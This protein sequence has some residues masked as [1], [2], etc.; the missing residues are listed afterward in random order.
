VAQKV[1][2][3][4]ANLGGDHADPWGLRSGGTSRDAAAAVSRVLRSNGGIAATVLAAL[5]CYW[6][7]SDAIPVSGGLGY[8]G[9]RYAR[10]VRSNPVLLFPEGPRAP[11]VKSK[12]DSYAARRFLPSTA[13]HFVM[14]AFD[15]PRT[16]D[17]VIA[18][19]AAVNLALLAL[20]IFCLCRAADAVGLTTR[21]KWMAVLAFQV[22]YANWKMP[23]FYPVL[24]D[25]FALALGALSLLF[26]LER[27][28]LG[29]VLIMVGGGFVWPTLPYFCFLL[30]AFPSASPG[31]VRPDTGREPRGWRT[32]PTGAAGTAAVLYLA[33]ITILVRN[34]YR[35]PGTPVKPLTN[36]VALSASVTALYVFFGLR[37]L[38]DS[39]G[40]WQ[41][42]RPLSVLRR[43]RAWVAGLLLV[44]I[45][46]GVASLAVSQADY[47]GLRFVTDTLFSSVTQPGIFCLAHIL[48]FGP[49]LILV[50]FLWGPMCRSIQRRGAGLTLCF[51][52][53]LAIGAGSESRKLMNF[54]PFVAL[55]LAER[56]DRS[57]R[58]A[59]H[60]G[61]LAILSL[62]VSKVWLPMGQDLPVPLLGTIP[63]RSLY[64]SSRGPWIDHASYV[65]QGAFVSIVAVLVYRSFGP[66]LRRRAPDAQDL[67][68]AA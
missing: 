11:F 38:L 9:I 35:I 57:V 45:E 58:G 22:S 4:A 64:V 39:P 29:L 13:L 30:L 59:W 34:D 47:S 5:C 7:L 53:A 26:Y 3:R 6:P 66:V 50:P 33:L 60:V 43:R 48:F 20:A 31:P 32:L 37:T 56:L 12:L 24:T 36:L 42:L 15:V 19:F 51:A 67:E 28:T 23:F 21:G 65:L 68:P 25:T 8:D 1:P 55:F 40:L 54:F 10:W 62:L 61:M 49:M 16:D 44:G 2:V 52:L 14:R 27:R 17:N 41:E 46:A 18:A 63:W